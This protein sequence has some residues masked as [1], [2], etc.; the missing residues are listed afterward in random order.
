M[1][2]TA[3]KGRRGEDQAFCTCEDCGE[4]AS[5]SA[6]HGESRGTLRGGKPTLSI[7]SEAA[8]IEALRK[9]G[10]SNIKNRL[11]CPKCTAA[12]MLK[13]KETTMAQAPSPSRQMTDD[14]RLD[15]M[16]VLFAS[17][18]RKAK[19]YTGQETDATVAEAV[20]GGCMPGWVAKVRAENFGPAGNEEA[21]AIRAEYLQINK[22]IAEVTARLDAAFQQISKD[23]AAAGARLDA[24]YRA[25]DKR[26][27]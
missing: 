15:I 7:Q 21:E 24:L 22:N 2:I 10:W 12:R 1:G 23:V 3:I 6:R 4:E 5:V 17:Y 8:V 14:V 13:Q 27:R 20:G 11:R 16:E 26:V 18:D 9:L 25:E 19:R